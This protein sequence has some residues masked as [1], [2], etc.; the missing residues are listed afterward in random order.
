M[1]GP[2]S[3][4]VGSPRPR[5]RS[6]ES[7]EAPE[8]RRATY[9]IT[10]HT[11]VGRRR[12]RPATPVVMSPLLDALERR[13]GQFAGRSVARLATPGPG[14]SLITS[15]STGRAREPVHH[16]GVVAARSPRARGWRGCS[17]DPER[18]R[19]A[20][21]A[22]REHPPRAVAAA[23]R[24]ARAAA[25]GGRRARATSPAPTRAARNTSD[26]PEHDAGDHEAL[27][28]VAGRRPSARRTSTRVDHEHRARQRQRDEHEQVA[29]PQR[30]RGSCATA[31]HVRCPARV[32][33]VVV[34]ERLVPHTV[35]AARQRR[36]HVHGHREP[37]R[38]RVT[39]ARR[40]RRCESS[41]TSPAITTAGTDSALIDTAA[42][43]A[44]A[45][46]RPRSIAARVVAVAQRERDREHRERER[47]AV[48]VDRA[49]DP[50]HRAAGG[51]QPGGEQRVA[52]AGRDPAGARVDRDGQQH[53]RRRPRA[54]AARQ[55]AEPDEV[56]D[57][58]ERQ[59]HGA[60]ARED[61]AERHTRR[62]ASP[63]PTT[64]KTP[65]SN[66][67]DRDAKRRRQARAASA[68]THPRVPVIG[69]VDRRLSARVSCP[70]R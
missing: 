13:V 52:R 56:G 55:R 9:E 50:E 69:G 40:T 61:V 67:S 59:E 25:R 12:V 1:R 24:A 37:G 33:V 39:T 15:A 18:A 16:R 19:P 27:H 31:S 51:D 46:P 10:A 38:R 23:P 43:P 30:R 60:L 6:R 45:R 53:A 14:S 28:A 36:H 54:G 4:A 20:T 17:H 2:N 42:P 49:G 65:S 26:G 66:T 57:P 58:H 5:A 29:V 63:V 35:D 22:D 41:T 62:R 8:V 3:L 47:R 44:E 21:T 32:G 68:A 70:E 64:P 7:L 11:S 34:R 48:G